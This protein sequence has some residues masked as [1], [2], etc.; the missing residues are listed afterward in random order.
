MIR[1]KKWRLNSSVIERKEK[2]MKFIELVKL[3]T[4]S[5]ISENNLTKKRKLGKEWFESVKSDI[6]YTY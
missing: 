2:I 1:S 5:T 6:R 3:K 4:E